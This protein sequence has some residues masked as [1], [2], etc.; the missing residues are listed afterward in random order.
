MSS[1]PIRVIVAD[2]HGMVRRGIVSFLKNNADIHVIGEAQDGRQAVELCEHLQPDV[3]LMDLQMPEMDGVAATRAIRKQSPTIQVIALTSFQDRDK[4]QEALYA[5][6]ISYLLKN[7]S[8]DDLAAA[9]RN[10]HAG[11]HYPPDRVIHC[12]Q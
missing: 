11:R 3:V 8:G 5:G 2:D 1:N 4:V 6:A 12:A 7:V 10:A 9:I